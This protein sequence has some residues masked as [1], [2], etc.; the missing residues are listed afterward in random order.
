MT[1]EVRLRAL[2]ASGA[3]AIRLGDVELAQER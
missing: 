1:P 2:A 3:I